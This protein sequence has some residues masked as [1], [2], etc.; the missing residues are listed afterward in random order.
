MSESVILIVD[1]N[2]DNLKLLSDMLGKNGYKTRRAISANLA[3]QALNATR[4]DLIL[5]DITMPDM[6][7]YELCKQIKSNPKFA[8]IPIIFISALND[9]LDKVKAF[10]VGGVDYITKPFQIEEVT[11]RVDNQLR[12]VSL[13]YDL[14]RLNQQLDD[15]NQ[16]LELKQKKLQSSQARIVNNSLKDPITNL[17]QKIPFMGRLR[18]IIEQAKIKK[19]FDY[20]LIV[21]GYEQLKINRGILS[22][23]EYN[24]CLMEIGEKINQVTPSNGM[25][26]KIAE[27]EFAIIV[28]EVENSQTIENIIRQIKIRLSGAFETCG[29]KIAL[30]PNYGMALGA[31]HYQNPEALFYDAKIAL[32]ESTEKGYGSYQLFNPTIKQKRLQRLEMQ[33][34]FHN[35]LKKKNF[36]I[37]YAYLTD[38]AI[39]KIGV[40]RAKVAWKYGQDKTLDLEELTKMAKITGLMSEFNHLIFGAIFRRL[41]E[42]QEALLWQTESELNYAD[43]FKLCLHLSTEQFLT[44]DLPQQLASIIQENQC[45]EKEGFV[46][47]FS[48][49]TLVINLPQALANIR[50]IQQLG[51]RLIPDRQGIN[52]LKVLE[53]NNILVE[54]LKTNT[55]TSAMPNNPGNRDLVANS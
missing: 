55:L 14:K 43:D 7:G 11:A 53:Q 16:L 21:I 52:Y 32:A 30:N 23:E 40:V 49:H 45:V 34:A 24:K 27:N 38:L 5:L 46:L 20:L 50:A 37:H 29:C 13:Q 28:K 35:A 1:D 17:N 47:E 15:K 3:L 10:N 12:I 6:N 18:Q 19:S 54:P 9:V 41:R 39:G 44:V 42:I 2:L 4:F 48:T 31:S 33:V 25:S 26:G 36:S 22:L 51:I 8:E